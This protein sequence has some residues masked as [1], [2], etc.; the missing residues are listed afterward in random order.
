MHAV[1][2][3]FALILTVLPASVRVLRSGL[4]RLLAA[5]PL[6]VLEGPQ[7]EERVWRQKQLPSQQARDEER[8]RVRPQQ[9][10]RQVLA[11]AVSGRQI[12]P[13]H[14]IMNTRLWIA[15]RGLPHYQV[16]RKSDLCYWGKSIKTT[17][18]TKDIFSYT[19]DI[20]L[21]LTEEF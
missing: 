17:F 6:Q 10:G 5:Q 12:C 13:A 19:E 14:K 7:H 1:L 9:R 18:K 21:T 16:K 20:I 2:R 11:Q 4:R 8:G 3:L 15:T